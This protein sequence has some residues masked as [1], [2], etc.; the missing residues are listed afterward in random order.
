[1]SSIRRRRYAKAEQKLLETVALTVDAEA[2][3]AD[4]ARYQALRETLR[5]QVEDEV[6]REGRRVYLRARLEELRGQLAS[7]VRD[8]ERLEDELAQL[9]G[10][11][12]QP[13][14]ARLRSV[15]EDSIRP[16]YLRRRRGER[17]TLGV[18]AALL[19]LTVSPYRPAGLL[20]GGAHALTHS[21]SASPA[22]IVETLVGGSLLTALILGLAVSVR[23][24]RRSLAIRWPRIWH[25]TVAAAVTAG[26]LLTGGAVE[27]NHATALSLKAE[28][29]LLGSHGDY[30]R[31]AD[32]AANAET[33]AAVLLW[34]GM[35][36][37]GITVVLA[38]EWVRVTRGDGGSVLNRAQQR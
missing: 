37:L 24:S 35:L 38:A 10:D 9:G 16:D 28:D 4:V 32:Q 29:V 5:R 27:S 36:G 6:P 22:D 1:M 31:L 25:V 12:S 8:F 17:L 2:A 30:P 26:L 7:G 23:P 3:A 33:W 21:A 11:S 34:T 13:L 19:V 14:D 18:L 15:I 20:Q